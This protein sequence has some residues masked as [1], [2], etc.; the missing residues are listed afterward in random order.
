MKTRVSQ[1]SE[2]ACCPP[3][4]VTQRVIRNG[5]AL[6]LAIGL[7]SCSPGKRFDQ[8]AWENADLTGRERADMLQD[9]LRRYPLEG[10]TRTEVISLLGNPTQTDKWEGAD[11]IYVLGND[12]SYMPID[13]AWLLVDL[14]DRERVISVRQV[15]D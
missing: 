4:P 5:A 7:I 9:L 11:M 14:D 12:G 15:V 3:K 8:A 1:L 6:L 2:N 10:R 13:N